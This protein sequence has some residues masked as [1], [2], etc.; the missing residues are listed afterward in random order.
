MPVYKVDYQ[1]T[2]Q[3]K[4]LI[5]DF[6]SQS[7]KLNNFYDYP[8]GIEGFDTLIKAKTLTFDE[9]KRSKLV[10]VLLQQHQ[11]L[12]TH[13]KVLKNIQLLKQANTFTVTTGHQL[14]LMTGP[15]YYFYKTLSTIKL[16]EILQEKYPAYHFVPVF[17]MASEDHDFEEVN[18]FYFEDH[19]IEWDVKSAGAVGRQST[20]NMDEMID[21]L[22]RIWG[23]Q[24][25]AE[26]LIGLFKKAYLANQNWAEATRCLVHH[27][28]GAYGLVTL[29][30]DCNELKTAWVPYMQTEVKHQ[31]THQKVSE[32]NANLKDLQYDVQ[33]NPRDINLFYLDKERVRITKTSQ[34]YETVEKKKQ[35]SLDELCQDMEHSPEKFSPNALLR[36]LYQEVVLPNLAYVGGAGELAYWLQLNSSFKAFDVMFPKLIL[37]DSATM[38]TAK[39]WQKAKKLSMNALDFYSD[40]SSVLKQHTQKISQTTI[41]FDDLKQQL[42]VQFEILEDKMKFTD[43]SFQNALKAQKQKQING[44]NHLEKR[45]WKAEQKKYADQLERIKLLHQL[46]QPKGVL[47]E[48]KQNFS[49]FYLALGEDF[50]KVVYEA[51][52]PI[53]HQFKIIVY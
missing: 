43:P 1:E 46:H 15:A 5:Q 47:Q 50:V 23:K 38:M 22:Y 9:S 45:W 17:W 25:K 10:D 14:N 6:L 41:S 49:V 44:L 48:R 31:L 8:H 24:E 18:H 26:V 12:D 35:W 33:V 37:R 16:A 30:G 27:F 28:F 13:P 42:A 53:E 36:P 11:K 29:D 4:P 20:Q 39:N 7:P 34:H 2:N 3:F 40:L 52:N 21:S 19:T 51:M 32:T